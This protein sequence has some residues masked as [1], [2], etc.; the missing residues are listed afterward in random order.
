M[1]LF[2]GP[3]V[4]FSK[5]DSFSRS[6]S[7]AARPRVDGAHAL[8]C[9]VIISSGLLIFSPQTTYS[10]YTKKAE[11]TSWKTKRKKL[12]KFNF[13]VGS[14]HYKLFKPIASTYTETVK[15]KLNQAKLCLQ[16]VSK[17]EGQFIKSNFLAR[18]PRVGK[19]R[20]ATA[21]FATFIVVVEET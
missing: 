5:D 18:G 15:C 12:P 7:A 20:K 6:N 4:F 8:A 1:F 19:C 2:S 3:W 10:T 21:I 11:K 16:L 13:L 14:L 9:L 17:R